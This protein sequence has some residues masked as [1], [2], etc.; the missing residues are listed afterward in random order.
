M[1][2]SATAVVEHAGR[3][4]AWRAVFGPVDAQRP[5]GKLLAVKLLDGFVN[6]LVFREFY[7]RETSGTARVA[8][9]GQE[10]VDDGAYF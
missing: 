1:A 2:T 7:E 4:G 6:V 9:G 3:S 8:V 5:A 10:N